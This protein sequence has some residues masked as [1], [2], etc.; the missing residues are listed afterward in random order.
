MGLIK[1]LD[2]LVELAFRLLQAY[3]IKRAQAERDRLEQD[4]AMWFDDHFNG[5]RGTMSDHAFTT[6]QTDSS[7]S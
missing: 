2:R 5:V 1:L 7:K 4:P 3:R 6:K